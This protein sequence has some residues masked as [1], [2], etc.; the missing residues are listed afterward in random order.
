MRGLVFAFTV[1]ALIAGGELQPVAAQR[2]ASEQRPP[3]PRT[4]WGDPDLQGLWNYGTN[5][6]LQRPPEYAGQEWLTEEEVTAAN[7]K[8]A[9]FATSERRSELTAQYDLSLNYNQVWWDLGTSTGRTSLIT[10]PADGRRPP[11]TP[12]RQAYEET[13]EAQR[14]QTIRSGLAPPDG[15]I[16]AK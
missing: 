7:L 10:D 14:L 2:V 4:P 13:P 16:K 3:V 8:S 9:T 15:G 11:L 1:L 12:E 5:T 6:P